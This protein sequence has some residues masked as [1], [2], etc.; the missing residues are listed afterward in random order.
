MSHELRTPLSAILLWTTLIEEEKL[1]EREQLQEAL[2]A[3]KH[4]AEELQALIDN[5][6]ETTRI[7]SGRFTLQRTVGEIATVVEAAIAQVQPAAQAKQIPLHRQIEPASAPVDRARLQ[8]TLVL[9]LQNA[10]K[11]TPP[12]GRVELSVGV[13]DEEMRIAVHDTGAGLTPE[14][15]A[16]VFSGPPPSAQAKAP[17]TDAGLGYGLIV[18]QQ[19][20]RAHGG[21]LTAASGGPGQGATFT[22]R[23]PLDPTRAIT[24]VAPEAHGTAQTLHGRRV[25]LVV[26][27]A[28]LRHHLAAGLH[29]AG[30]AV[31]AVDSAPAAAEAAERQYHDVI[32]CDLALPT[33]DA[34]ELLQDLREH[35]VTHARPHAPALALAHADHAD[36]ASLALKHGFM[37]CLQAPVD[38]ATLAA[39]AAACLAANP[40]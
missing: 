17:R 3:I 20:V 36:A 18:A 25:L 37:R 6:V 12:G 38:P 11:A 2:A 7:V 39:A 23:L 16:R 27:D 10:I 4:S 22:I 19:L 35:E 31:S 33:I 14:R 32:V 34:G 21:V 30:A 29:D 13:H 8:Q 26:D 5:L 1:E 15:L 28:E 24:A 40:R 9:L